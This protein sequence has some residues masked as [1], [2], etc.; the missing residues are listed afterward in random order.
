MTISLAVPM[1]ARPVVFPPRC[2]SCEGA[3]VAESRLL[4][5][6]LVADRARGTQ[7][8]VKVQLQIPHC[9]AC[10]RRTKAVFLAGLVPFVVGFLGVGGIAFAMVGFGA[11][12]WGLDELGRPENSNSLVLGAAAGLFAGIVAGFVFELIARVLLLPVLGRALL[13]APLLVPSLFTDA[14]HVAGLTGRPNADFTQLALTFAN[15]AVARDFAAANASHLRSN[16]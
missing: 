16:P 9:A 2:V 7:K 14:D 10:A 1:G 8:A 15:D 5:T 12:A 6:K 13:Q 4:V 11:F 3:P